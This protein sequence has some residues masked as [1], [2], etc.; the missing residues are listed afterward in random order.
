MRIVQIAATPETTDRYAALFALCDDGSL[1]SA[2]WMGR[3]AVEWVP[4]SAPPTAADSGAPV[5]QTGNTLKAAIARVVEASSE[6]ADCGEDHDTLKR[7][8]AVIEQR[9][10]VRKGAT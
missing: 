2:I 10:A 5:E 3:S 6:L 1:W 7:L 8:L 4:V 9:A